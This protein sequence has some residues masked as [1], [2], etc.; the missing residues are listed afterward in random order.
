MDLIYYEN[1][2]QEEKSSTVTLSVSLNIKTT[3]L[4]L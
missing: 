3:L 2:Q 4:I 1:C